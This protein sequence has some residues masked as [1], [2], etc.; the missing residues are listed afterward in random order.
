MGR[1]IA[2]CKSEKKGT[3]KKQISEVNL[4]EN[5]G[6]E[7]DA[8]GGNWHRQVSL[9]DISKIDIFNEKGGNVDYG[10]FGEN[11][12]IEGIDLSKIEIGEKLRVGE[13]ELEITQIGK[14]CHTKCEIFYRVGECI[15]PKNGIFAK[16]IKGGK[17]ALGDDIIKIQL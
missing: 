3:A 5:F 7:G 12:V 4:I 17:V 10:D 2:I 11:L 9:L 16:V 15:M 13:C 6:L 8:H 1:I 14:T